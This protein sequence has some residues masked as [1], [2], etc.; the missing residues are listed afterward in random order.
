MSTSSETRLAPLNS[1]TN[2]PHLLVNVATKRTSSAS[3]ERM[4]NIK[5]AALDLSLF[6]PSLEGKLT[7]SV[8]AT[9]KQ[10]A[11]D[12]TTPH[13]RSLA[14]LEKLEPCYS[15]LASHLHNPY[16]TREEREALARECD[17]TMPAITAWFVT[18]RQRIGW[19][20]LRAT[21]FSRSQILMVAAAS[22]FWPERDTT[23]P[24][25]P[26]LELRF[27]EIEANVKSL[28]TNS[29]Q[30]SD[31]LV[32]LLKN[33]NRPTNAKEPS[34]RSASESN[35]SKKRRSEDADLDVNRPTKRRSV[36]NDSPKASSGRASRVRPSP[37]SASGPMK[38]TP[39]VAS[40]L[41]L[42]ISPT[43]PTQ[44]TFGEP[45]LQSTSPTSSLKRSRSVDDASPD[46]KRRRVLPEWRDPRSSQAGT[47]RG[48]RASDG[49]HS[50]A[51]CRS[52]SSQSPKDRN[53]RSHGG[54]R[55]VSAPVAPH[56]APS[57]F[58]DELAWPSVLSLP[59]STPQQPETTLLSPCN[60]NLDFWNLLPSGLDAD[61][62]VL[63]SN[64]ISY[65][66]PPSGKASEPFVDVSSS[67]D[68]IVMSP[69]SS[70]S[71]PPGSAPITPPTLIP[72]LTGD[73]IIDLGT[74]PWGGLFGRS[75]F[76][77]DSF[78]D[79]SA[80]SSSDIDF[81]S[82]LAGDKPLCGDDY[83]LDDFLHP[84]GWWETRVDT[85]PR[86]N[87]APIATAAVAE[88]PGKRALPTEN[89][90]LDSAP[91]KRRRLTPAAA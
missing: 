55:T 86:N 5:N 81:L 48:V 6:L 62:P 84:C 17:R 77:C 65:N 87:V 31:T 67:F 63:A 33:E 46:A 11:I 49:P 18:A 47:R 89:E 60:D 29:L 43:Q 90:S 25:P 30:P 88:R 12:K 80:P 27:A 15:W 59:T 64:D 66:S 72:Q 38:T 24:L 19:S 22:R 78:P 34:R 35:I 40:S 8:A 70:T 41:A 20:Q 56:P 3:V 10:P 36:S 42:T 44:P 75:D 7:H 21:R 14:A 1:R 83:S 50:S 82:M 2:L 91:P 37:P 13:P 54:R 4:S 73:S 85:L 68:P 71:S 53:G 26:D 45:S 61:I 23:R 28:Y 9:S 39:S 69:T 74:D 52:I 79:L 57:A 51:S 76:T 58:I 16:P 32:R